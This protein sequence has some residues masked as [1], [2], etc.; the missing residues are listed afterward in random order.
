MFQLSNQPRLR[1]YD[2]PTA[3][4][5]HAQSVLDAPLRHRNIKEVRG[6]MTFIIFE[7]F[8]KKVSLKD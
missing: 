6:A 1:C 3:R 2:L 5:I 8:L 7:L 4:V